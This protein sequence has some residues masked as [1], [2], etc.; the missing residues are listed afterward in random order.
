[1]DMCLFEYTCQD[2]VK[3]L[4]KFPFRFFPVDADESLR[5]GSNSFVSSKRDR[6]VEVFALMVTSSR[7]Q[8]YCTQVGGTKLVSAYYFLSEVEQVSAC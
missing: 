3:I 4:T 1:M 8:L 6:L 5:T 7:G 2:L